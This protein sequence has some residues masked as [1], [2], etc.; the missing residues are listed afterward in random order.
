MTSNIKSTFDFMKSDF[1]STIFP[2][3]TN[4]IVAEKSANE[5]SNHI[6]KRILNDD[7]PEDSFLSQQ[8]VYSTKPLG[9]LR[10]TVKLDPV[11]EYFIYDLVYRNKGIF[12]KAVSENRKCFGYVFKNGNYVSVHEAY[13]DYKADLLVNDFVYKHKI[14]FD[15]ASY[16]NSLYHHDLSHW[17][18]NFK[19]VSEID[20]K[21][22]SQFFR[23]INSG[24]SIDFLPQ[25]IYPSKMIGNEFLKFIDLHGQI[26]SECIIRFMDDFVIFDDN[27]DVIKEDFVKIQKLLGQ[28]ALN[29]NPSK[30]FIDKPFSDVSEKIS[31]IKNSLKE[32]VVDWES[33]ITASSVEVYEEI[34]Q[35]H[36]NKLNRSQV[37]ELVALLK[38]ESLE[39]SE[40]DLILT[41][42]G[43]HSDSI[44]EVL[45]DL[46]KKF[47]NLI[48]HIYALSSTISDKESLAEVILQFLDEGSS[49]IEYQL[50]WIVCIAEDYLSG[51]KNFGKLLLKIFELS[52]DL[53]IARAKIL[54]IPINNFGLKEI[55][56]D[57]L[58]SGQSDWLSWAS[59]VGSR[60]LN[61]DERNY[62]LNY[63]SKSSSMNY[64]IANS[65]KKF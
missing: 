18:S 39:E 25:G 34:E 32:I 7:T 1:P 28:Y 60:A 29:V 52:V 40:A 58:K 65:V 57:Y 30:T 48:K 16:F 24:R 20:K 50:F 42:I 10:R 11:A 47:P 8:R 63:F 9:H 51:T 59:A 2:L 38:N 6:T 4:L 53:K 15:I 19:S 64:L 54:E 41:F 33:F 23:E 35:E 36:E 21:G 46:L 49:F 13:K 45:P 5:I 56:L 44:L 14:Q 22:F 62:V 37:E 43:S 31:D 26:K 12:R 3:K 27:P 61:A 17:F 55:R